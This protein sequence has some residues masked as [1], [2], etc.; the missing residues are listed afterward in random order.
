MRTNVPRLL[1]LA[2]LILLVGAIYH[3][4][5]LWMR[6]RDKSACAELVCYDDS[7]C[8]SACSCDRSPEASS[9][10]CVGK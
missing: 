5:G 2:A 7:D 9:G 8:G 1:K 10:K 6:G 4:A 3:A